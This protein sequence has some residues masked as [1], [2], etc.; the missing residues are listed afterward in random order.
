MINE[1]G[2]ANFLAAQMI[3]GTANVEKQFRKIFEKFS[4]EGLEK[5]MRKKKLDAVVTPGY[6]IS[7]VLAIG[8]FPGISV[9]AGFD[10]KGV[11][12]GICFGGLKGSEPKLIEIAYA[13]EQ[14]TNVRKPPSFKP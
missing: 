5:L 11:P 7:F 12:F 9:P 4:R 6:D 2:Q 14:A 8:G 3:N 1:Y 10:K 13:F